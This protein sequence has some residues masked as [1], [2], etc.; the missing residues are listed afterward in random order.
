MIRKSNRFQSWLCCQRRI[1]RIHRYV[2]EVVATVKTCNRR[3]STNRPSER[4]YLSYRPLTKVVKFYSDLLSHTT[5]DASQ[6]P[7]PP[8]RT[9]LTISSAESRNIESL[10]RQQISDSLSYFLPAILVMA[11]ECMR[12]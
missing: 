12:L 3:V 8:V 1:Q 9:M 11:V 7:F 6:F 2:G 4:L 10:E 5:Q